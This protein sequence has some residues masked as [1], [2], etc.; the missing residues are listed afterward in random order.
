MPRLVFRVKDLIGGH[1]WWKRDRHPI[2]GEPFNSGA[3][4]YGC[5]E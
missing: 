5:D 3:V 1:D 4:S 2:Y